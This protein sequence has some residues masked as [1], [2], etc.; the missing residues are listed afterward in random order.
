ML[1]I[2]SIMSTSFLK[3]TPILMKIFFISMSIGYCFSL[4]EL[5]FGEPAPIF[6]GKTSHEGTL[7]A[8][9][10]VNGDR[11]SDLILISSL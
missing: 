10:D 6:G 2:E 4:S 8:L 7:A 3:T 11:S 9:M 5:V 1:K